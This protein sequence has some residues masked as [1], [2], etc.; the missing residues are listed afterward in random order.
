MKRSHFLKLKIMNKI[1]V[2]VDFSEQ[3]NYALK[4]AA[5]I[6]E[7]TN[8]EVYLLHL[9]ELPSGVIDMAAGSNFSIPESMMYLRKIK[10]KM[11]K[12]KEYYFVNRENVKY[13][14]RFNHPYQ[15]IKEYSEKI[16]PNLIIMGAKGVSDFEEI[17][18][19]SNTEKIVRTSEIPV[20][21]VKSNSDE[22]RL[23][24]IVFASDFKDESKVSFK[25]LIEFTSGLDCKIHLLFVNTMDRFETT[26]STTE[27]IQSFL[28]DFENTDQY[29]I[30]T[31]N[32]NTIIKGIVNFSNEI[33]TD[34]IALSTHNRSGLS[35]L[36]N[37]SIAK[38]LSKTATKPIVTFKI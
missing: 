16:N 17:M 26:E 29:S 2:P 28:N 3:S 7:K 12:I 15:G 38:S 35:K 23:N 10:D 9:V 4:T 21:V 24:N 27:R 1:L 30:N 33:N 25:K 18:I 14:I 5:S 37:D 6:S 34:L 19:G 13:S 11:L 31:Y 8:A 36:F 22:F 32:D 20:I